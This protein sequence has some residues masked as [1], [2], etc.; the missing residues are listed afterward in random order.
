MLNTTTLQLGGSVA[1]AAL[2]NERS[3]LTHVLVIQ[4]FAFVLVVALALV[5]LF[6]FLSDSAAFA[7]LPAAAVPACDARR[8]PHE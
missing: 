8:L 2:H 7:S 4:F 6:Q 5:F 1:L 3:E